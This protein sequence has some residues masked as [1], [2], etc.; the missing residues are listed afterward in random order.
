MFRQL[1]I[2]VNSAIAVTTVNPIWAQYVIGTRAGTINFTAGKVSI[3]GQIPERNPNPDV[4]PALKDGQ[5]L[6]TAG[7]GRA[8]ILLGPWVFLRLGPHAA[9]RML[10]STLTDAQMKIE[11]GVALIEVIEIAN[12]N[13]VHVLVG[14]TSTTFR[15]LGLHRFDADRGDLR[16]YGG[17]ADVTAGAQ[18]FDVTRGRVLHLNTPFTE[19]RFGT[20]KKDSLLRWAAARSFDLYIANPEAR[21]RLANW[22]PNGYYYYNRDFGI[23]F[24]SSVETQPPPGPPDLVDTSGG[25]FR[26]TVGPGP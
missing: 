20:G 23:R 2:L 18:I 4:F 21:A 11:Q 16:V 19:S 24:S 6:R 7:D 13:K 26:G 1:L 9:V 10:N 5:V 8:E 3:D 12:G 17:H 14:T 15:G 22:E 25:L